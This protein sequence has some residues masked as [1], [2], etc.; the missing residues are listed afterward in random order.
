MKRRDG[1]FTSIHRKMPNCMPMMVGVGI[2]FWLEGAGAGSGFTFK[3]WGVLFQG[4]G[5]VLAL[6]RLFP[7]PLHFQGTHF[8]Q[9]FSF[10]FSGPGPGFN[11]KVP[12]SGGV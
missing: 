7:E 5:P 8:S 11:R 6:N 3:G 12:S 2:G 9:P 1:K 4:D 10:C